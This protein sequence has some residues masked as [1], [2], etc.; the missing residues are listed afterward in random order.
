MF[1]T[2]MDIVKSA[3]PGLEPFAAAI[4]WLAG[5]L[6]DLLKAMGGLI[7]RMPDWSRF[8][9]LLAL[10]GTVLGGWGKL[11][12]AIQLAT[13]ELRRFL[14]LV[15]DGPSAFGQAGRGM[16]IGRGGRP[17]TPGG[18]AGGGGAG[19]GGG[20]SS[21]FVSGGRGGG[22]RQ[23]GQIT[24]STVWAPSR[25]YSD[26]GRNVL[27]RTYGNARD[28]G[29]VSVGPVGAQ[30]R[31]QGRFGP[32][33][34]VYMG[35]MPIPTRWTRRNAKGEPFGMRGAVSDTI[36]GPRSRDATGKTQVT[37]AQAQG[38]DKDDGTPLVRIQGCKAAHDTRPVRLESGVAD[39]RNRPRY[40]KWYADV[41]IDFD[42]DAMTATDVANL[43][44]RAGAQVGIC[45]GRPGSTNSFGIGFGTFKVEGSKAKRAKVAA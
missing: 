18:M 14:G 25:K 41:V 36:G 22:G 31:R 30:M 27:N 44:H 20:G 24:P 2:L 8:I 21:V 29:I 16:F 6:N 19:G 4:G 15:P 38:F 37:W 40:D 1:G 42:A 9:G 33:S 34:P 13:Y 35:P 32:A 7:S 10:G 28:S 3:L 17:D 23:F 26:I 12:L 43:L 5:K 45:E 39:L 11:R